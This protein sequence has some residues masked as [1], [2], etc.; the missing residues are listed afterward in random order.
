MTR[1]RV[2]YCPPR[3]RRR[4]RWCATIAEQSL[5]LG[6]LEAVF[7]RLDSE[8]AAKVAVAQAR[9]HEVAEAVAAVAWHATEREAYRG[10]LATPLETPEWA[11]GKDW[12]EP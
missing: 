6:S 11:D 9:R 8:R 3:P 1:R 2:R 5:E 4:P 7:T 12:S 10:W